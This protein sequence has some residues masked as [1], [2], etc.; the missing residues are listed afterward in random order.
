M[1]FEEAFY[2]PPIT[3]THK[4]IDDMYNELEQNIMKAVVEVGI[5][6]D[7][8]R[9]LELIEKD[10]PHRPMSISKH[11]GRSYGMYGRCARCNYIV[12]LADNYCRKCGS[13]LD[14][15]GELEKEDKN[16]D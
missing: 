15:S 9:L 8:E 11:G 7:K 5:N 16:D 14:W 3:I 10:K 1:T 4:I 13:Y 6:I 2:R 12:T